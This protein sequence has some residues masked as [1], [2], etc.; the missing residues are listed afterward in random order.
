MPVFYAEQMNW[1]V[2]LIESVWML[3][4]LYGFV[5]ALRTRMQGWRGGTP[6]AGA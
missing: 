2:L 1:S 6:G 5:L 4:S 3:I